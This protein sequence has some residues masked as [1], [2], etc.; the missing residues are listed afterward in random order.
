MRRRDKRKC[1]GDYAANYRSLYIWIGGFLVEK[2]R[3]R[4]SSSFIKSAPATN[5]ETPS[6]APDR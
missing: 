3:R 5:A 1:S 6:R 2:R 4:L